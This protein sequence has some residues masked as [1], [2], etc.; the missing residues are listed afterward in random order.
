MKRLFKWNSI[1]TTSK[2]WG[3]ALSD[4][5]NSEYLWK[6]LESDFKDAIALKAVLWVSWMKMA[7]C[8][9]LYF[10]ISLCCFLIK[11]ISQ[12]HVFNLWFCFVLLRNL[13]CKELTLLIWGAVSGPHEDSPRANPNL[14]YLRT[15]VEGPK[16]DALALPACSQLN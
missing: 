14:C 4:N 12:C 6:N 1:T 5:Q 16:P 15:A 3:A 7:K 10:K 8:I 2:H 11:V 13:L 9:Y